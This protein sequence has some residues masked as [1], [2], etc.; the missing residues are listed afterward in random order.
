MI[1]HLA[2]L[3]DV[4]DCLLRILHC[5]CDFDGHVT[6]QISVR[7]HVELLGLDRLFVPLL[8]S[9]ALDHVEVPFL[10][11]DCRALPLQELLRAVCSYSLRSNDACCVRLHNLVTFFLPLQLLGFRQ[12]DEMNFRAV[13]LADT[14]SLDVWIV[15]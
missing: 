2:A 10:R 4:S 14:L 15:F 3:L 5:S 7:D 12:R 6:C 13:L 9:A 1:V 11:G 8:G